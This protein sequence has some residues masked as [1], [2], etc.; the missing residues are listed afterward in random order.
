MSFLSP[1]LLAVLIPLAGLPLILHLLNRGFPRHVPFPSIELIKET[2]ARRSKL[3]RWRHWVLL[4]LR[5]LF[6]LLLLL[7]FLQPVLKRLGANPADRAA[8]QVLIVLDQFEQWLHAKKNETN[9]ELVEALA[10]PE[11][12]T[13]NGAHGAL[14]TP[15]EFKHPNASHK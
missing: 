1:E 6:L 4:L 2:M 9:T 7:A 5:T 12:S 14:F 13:Q 3:H 15:R 8:R 10:Y 11:D